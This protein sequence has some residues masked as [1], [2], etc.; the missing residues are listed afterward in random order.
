MLAL[1]FLSGV[2]PRLAGSADALVSIW[3]LSSFTCVRTIDRLEWPVR[4]LGFS[5]DG[6][7]LAAGSE[8]LFIDVSSVSTG[9]RVVSFA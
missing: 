1:R 4:T 8:D 6:Q 5:A 2:F 9:A 7:Y 3:E